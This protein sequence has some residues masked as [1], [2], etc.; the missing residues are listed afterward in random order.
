MMYVHLVLRCS[1]LFRRILFPICSSKLFPVFHQLIRGLGGRG[2]RSFYEKRLI[3]VQ[4]SK[5]W[6]TATSTVLQ[7]LWL[8]ADAAQ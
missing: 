3:D 4:K 2:I 1:T 6:E 7:S 8:E 5:A